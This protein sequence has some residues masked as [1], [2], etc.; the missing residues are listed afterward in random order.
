MERRI[1]L[2]FNIRSN[3][4]RDQLSGVFR[5]MGEHAGWIPKLISSMD[6]FTPEVVENVERKGY[7]GNIINDT[8]ASGTIARL[9]NSPLPLAVLGIMAPE[10][11]A[12]RQAV[13]FTTHDNPSSGRL[14]AEKFFSHGEFASFCYVH[15]Q[16]VPDWSRQREKG[17]AVELK[18]RATCVQLKSF[19]LVDSGKNPLD[20][21]RDLPRPTAVLAANDLCAM[22]ILQFCKSNGIIVPKEVSVIGAGD[23]EIICEHTSPPLS[24]IRFDFVKDGY[25]ASVALEKMISS[26]RHRNASRKIVCYPNGISERESTAPVAPS[27]SLVRR[28]MEFIKANACKGISSHDVASALNVSESLLSLRFR[29]LPKTSVL[30]LINNTRLEAVKQLLTAT[31]RTITEITRQTGFRDVNNLKRLFRQRMG[32]SMR[33]FRKRNA[34]R[35]PPSD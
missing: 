22:E 29:E 26:R 18:R 19:S 14:A 16:N 20:A 33:E 1:L 5:F 23:D 32:M 2:V 35:Q 7:D 27:A 15:P 21:L 25:D 24:S 4:G 34:A 31:S 13:V 30:N 3:I 12:R 6:D 10:L 17:F 28:A 11:K 8:G 9:K